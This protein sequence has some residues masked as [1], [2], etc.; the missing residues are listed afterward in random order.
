MNDK[1]FDHLTGLIQKGM[2]DAT[3]ATIIE[4]RV[5]AVNIMRAACTDYIAEHKPDK[6]SAF[7]KHMSDVIQWA[8]KKKLN[9]KTLFE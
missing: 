5:I 8:D 4:Q 9:K 1:P 2:A 6:W 7:G 3:D